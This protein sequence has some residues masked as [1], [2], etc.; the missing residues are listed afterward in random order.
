L[1]PAERRQLLLEFDAVLGLDLG[2]SEPPTPLSDEVAELL[3][4]RE[5]ARRDRDYA[6]SDA[7]RDEL[8]ARG[9]DVRDTPHGQVAEVR[10]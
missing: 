9:V 10:R 3:R 4:R 8:A 6:T 1:T 2:R 5:Q 7:L